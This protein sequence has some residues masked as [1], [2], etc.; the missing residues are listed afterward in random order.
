MYTLKNLFL[1]DVVPVLYMDEV[2]G[3]GNHISLN[4][5][6]TIEEKGWEL[7]LMYNWHITLNRITIAWE[8][9]T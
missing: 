4:T 5:I 8:V 6:A 2:I 9:V 3:N 1:V 7:L